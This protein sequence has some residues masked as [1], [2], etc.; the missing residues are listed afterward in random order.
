M[1]VGHA[2]AGLAMQ[3]LLSNCVA[4]L[5]LLLIVKQASYCLVGRYFALLLLNL[6]VAVA[7]GTGGVHQCGQEPAAAHTLKGTAWV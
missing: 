4:C 2:R 1:L 5:R 6:V 3:V 7:A